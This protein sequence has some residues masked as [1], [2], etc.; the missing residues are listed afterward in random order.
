MKKLLGML[1]DWVEKGYVD[2]DVWKDLSK[3]VNQETIASVLNKSGSPVDVSIFRANQA[4]RLF[5]HLS[6]YVYPSELKEFA[7]KRL[8]IRET[9]YEMI[10]EDHI[11]AKR[12]NFEVN[13][14]TN[15]TIFNDFY[16]NLISLNLYNYRQYLDTF[17][18]KQFS[19]YVFIHSGTSFMVT[20]SEILVIE[21]FDE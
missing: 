3:F 4:D 19:N 5:S 21:I 6:Q 20:V 14:E 1:P 8:G 2:G 16:S 10:E 9:R 15:L 12:R 11:Y 18:Q 17:V 7:V 13:V